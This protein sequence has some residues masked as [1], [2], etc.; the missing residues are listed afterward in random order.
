MQQKNI[1]VLTS[2]LDGHL[3]ILEAKMNIIL[4]NKIN[5]MQINEIRALLKFCDNEFIPSLSSRSSTHQTS[6]T[7]ENK[8]NCI[9]TYVNE[10]ISQIVL[11]VYEDS[12][13][14]GF[15]SFING[16]SYEEIPDIASSNYIT[17]ICISHEH[18]NQRILNALYEFLIHK[19]PQKLVCPYI[20]T[21][22]W[23]TNIFH[24]RVLKK[25]DFGEVFRLSNHRG[26]GIDTVYYAKKM[27]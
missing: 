11:L 21:R 25:L 2:G 10:L 18:R 4:K 3:V 23:S 27:S 13:F 5:E 12:K 7:Q 22:T 24:I 15:L 26:I 20:S 16:F 14:A 9:D 6:F 1:P 8:Q 19:L 17:T